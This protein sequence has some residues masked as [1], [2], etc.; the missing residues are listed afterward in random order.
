[1]AHIA[2][3][4]DSTLYDFET[5]C[6]NEFMRLAYLK[7]DKSL[8]RG[9]YTPWVE[10]RSPADA[11]GLEAWLEIIERV[12]DDDMLLEMEP[13]PDAA[14][15][16]NQLQGFGHDLFY[17]SNRAT[18]RKSSTQAWLDDNGFPKGE[19]VCTSEDKIGYLTHCEYII[20]DRPSTLIKFT[21]DREW[22]NLHL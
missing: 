1:M 9:A 20:D 13:F 6:R 21:F 7:Q 5:P 11:C 17:I 12:H 3:D 14:L 4:I 19:L 22:N 18:D 8:F 2:V 10:W 15:I 16:L